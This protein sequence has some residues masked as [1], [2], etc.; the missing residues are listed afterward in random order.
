M[1]ERPEDELLVAYLDGELGEAESLALEDRLRLEPGLKERMRALAEAAT[2][3]REAFEPVL[4]EPVP[5]PLLRAAMPAPAE[6]EIVRLPRRF[7]RVPVLGNWIGIATAAALCG[8]VFGGSATYIAGR[9]Q[10]GSSVLDNIAGTHRFII[11]SAEAGEPVA[12]D[13]PAGDEQ[14]LPNAIR[15]PDMKPWGL[16]FKGARHLVEGG[17]SVYDFYFE[18]AAREP[19]PITFAVWP[20]KL[21]DSLPVFE[22]RGSLNQMYWRHA[23]HGFAITGVANK[24]YMWNMAQDIAW[25][26]R[27]N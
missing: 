24:G 18:S 19:G 17:K 7:P 8:I 5:G 16:T 27:T 4:R 11:D 15:I 9:S 1:S 3:V 25:Q 13:V 6:A 10:A 14:R 20:T 23:G 22:R 12:F 2:L 21:P 26:L